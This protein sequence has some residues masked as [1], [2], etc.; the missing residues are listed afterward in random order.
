MLNTD[1]TQIVWQ[2]NRIR[3]N[4]IIMYIFDFE[5]IQLGTYDKNKLNG[6]ME[7]FLEMFYNVQ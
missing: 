2:K 4:L 3:P 5:I 1:S 7:T 6:I